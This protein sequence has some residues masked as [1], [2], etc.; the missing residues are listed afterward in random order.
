MRLIWLCALLLSLFSPWGRAEV[1]VPPP[2]ARV[3]DLTG[4]L[5]GAQASEL[6]ERLRQLEA[7]KGSQI[8]LLIVPTTQPETV[9]QY[10]MRVAEAWKLGR[11]GVDDGILL[12]VAKEDRGARIEVGYGLEGAV[13]DIHAKRIIEEEIVPRF[14]QGDFFGGLNA[15][16]GRLI[17]L[18]NGEPL[19]EPS[20]TSG[21][22]SL[23]GAID[24]YLPMAMLF[25]FAGGG[26][27]RAVFGRFFGSTLAGGLGFVAAWWLLDVVGIAVVFGVF[28]FLVTL[29]A[30]SGVLRGGGSSGGGWS[31]GGGGFGGGGGGFG[32][33]GASGRW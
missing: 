15:A 9:E 3:T 1:A 25:A 31:S 2:Q 5:T 33:G 19:P 23:G 13:S 24:E 12:L 10:A 21:G 6:E 29:L 22:S 28:V 11:K 26:L 4:T 17:G 30:G 14:R 16:V 32:G 18:V 8:A 20:S 27:L 7:Q